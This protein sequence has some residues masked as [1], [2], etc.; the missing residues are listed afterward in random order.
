MCTAALV[1]I[2]GSKDPLRAQ[3]AAEACVAH[4]DLL[5]TLLTAGRILLHAVASSYEVVQM[6]ID[7]NRGC[8]VLS[9]LNCC[10]HGTDLDAHELALCMLHTKCFAH[11]ILHALFLRY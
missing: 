3:A 7:T 9:V 10:S 4:V 1:T 2:A 5:C 8:T 6:F 11:H